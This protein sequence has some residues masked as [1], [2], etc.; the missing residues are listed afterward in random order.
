MGGPKNLNFTINRRQ[1]DKLNGEDAVSKPEPHNRQVQGISKYLI[2]LCSSVKCLR[3]RREKRT[4][5]SVQDD[6]SHWTDGLLLRAKG[7][8]VIFLINMAFIAVAIGLL[9]KY[10]DDRGFLNGAVIYEGSC[11]LT[12][13]WSTALHLIINILST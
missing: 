4:A 1:R 8:A 5:Q 3:F 9:K 2:A 6:S 7:F 13:R 12:K 10:D 11:T